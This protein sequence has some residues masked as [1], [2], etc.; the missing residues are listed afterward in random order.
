MRVCKLLCGLAATLALL[1]GVTACGGGSVTATQGA[2]TADGTTE[3]AATSSTTSTGPTAKRAPPARWEEGKTPKAL[4][5]VGDRLTQAGYT[6]VSKSSSNPELVRVTMHAGAW[7]YVLVR[8]K[9]TTAAAMA[10]S[11]RQL[12]SNSRGRLVAT[13]VGDDVYVGSSG[14]ELLNAKRKLS[15]GQVAEFHQIVAAASG[16]G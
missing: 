13:I 1:V 4:T 12:N 2:A 11:I 5:A 6:P 10:R 7:A 16:Q 9:D 3:A 15:E 8:P 14:D